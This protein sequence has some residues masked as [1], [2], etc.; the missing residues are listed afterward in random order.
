M[1]ESM[2]LDNAYFSAMPRAPGV[3]SFRVSIMVMS[4]PMTIPLA[5]ARSSTS[6]RER[7]CLGLVMP[8]PNSKPV[9]PSPSASSRPMAVLIC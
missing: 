3:M 8:L 4:S 2:Y 1:P 5:L 6:R 9:M 7:P